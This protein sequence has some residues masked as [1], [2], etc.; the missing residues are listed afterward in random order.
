MKHIETSISSINTS[1]IYNKPYK[2]W[3]FENFLEQDV[4]DKILELDI[5]IGG[6]GYNNTRNVDNDETQRTY[7]KESTLK[8]YP[9]FKNIEDI[10]TND[11]FKKS[12]EA[13]LGVNLKKYPHLRVE[14]VQDVSPFCLVPHTDETVKACTILIYLSKDMDSESMGTELY[15]NEDMSGLTVKAPFI[16]NTGYIFLPDGKTTWHGIKEVNFEGI[17]KVLIINYVSSEWRDTHQLYNI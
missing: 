16:S 9:I 15:E 8:N 7:L 1:K 10:F 13:K 6:N 17:R 2:H 14:F 4:L 5:P 11:N 3:V 12:L